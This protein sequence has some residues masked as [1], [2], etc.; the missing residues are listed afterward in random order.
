LAGGFIQK[1]K[2]IDPEAKLNDI[3]DILKQV[4]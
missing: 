3:K 4:K 1:M 2:E